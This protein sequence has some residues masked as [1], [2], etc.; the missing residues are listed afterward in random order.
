[1]ARLDGG[2]GMLS[3]PGVP[4]AAAAEVVPSSVRRRG[5]EGPE[6]AAAA[7]A[8][9]MRERAKEEKARNGA[10]RFL[11][12][13][14][15]LCCVGIDRCGLRGMGCEASMLLGRNYPKFLIFVQ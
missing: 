6:E 12:S 1:M 14:G 2:R 13:F 5:F 10:G 9:K 8:E 11:S 7:L 15:E 3:S 4:P